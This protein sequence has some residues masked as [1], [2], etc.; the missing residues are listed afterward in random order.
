MRLL[1]VLRADLGARDVRGDRQHRHPAAL[2]VEET[3]DQMQ[4]ARAAAACADRQLSGQRGIG[5]R[6]ERG[7]LLVTDVL[8]SDFTGAPDRVGEAVE[9][10][11]G[12]AVDTAHTAEY[13]GLR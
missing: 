6:R 11:A 4:V 8:P 12:Q 1:E 9:A 7:R 10:V 3:V 13:V 2:R 5:G